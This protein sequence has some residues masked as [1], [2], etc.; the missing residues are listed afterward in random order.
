MSRTRRRVVFAALVAATVTILAAWLAELLAAGGFVLASA[1]LV[2]TFAVKVAWVA[3][4]FWNAVIGFVLLRRGRARLEGVVAAP[5]APVRDRI[6]VAMTVCNENVAHVIARLRSTKQSLDAGGH[7]GHFDFF[8]LSDSSDPAIAAA[9]AA[10]IAKWQAELGGAKNLIYRRREQNT[11]AQHGNLYDFCRRF[12]DGYDV[13]IV[14]DADSLMT[15]AAICQLVQIMQANPRIGMLQSVNSG[16]LPQ[17]LFARIFEFGHRH[18]MRCWMA[19]AVWWQGDRGQY[20]GHNA[21]IRVDAYAKNCSLAELP[22]PAPFGGVMFCHDQ[23]ESLLMH[24]AGFEVR[25][26]P[27]EHG[28]FEGMP[29]TLIDFVTRYCRWLQGN[30]TNLRMLRLGGLAAMD[31]YHLIGVA[32]RFMTWPAVVAFVALAAFLSLRWP[33]GAP[34]S[35]PS[36]LALYAT[37]FVIYFTPKLL[38]VLD[39][40]L[41]AP[42]TYGGVARLAAGTSLDVVLTVLFLPVTMLTATWFATG[43]PFGRALAWD[44]QKREG[45]RLSWSAAAQ[46]LWPHTA[47]GLGLLATLLVAAPA[48]VPWFLPFCAGLV[49]AIPFAAMTSS[50]RLNRLAARWKLFAL[51][52]DIATP[53][54]IASVLVL[55]AASGE[56]GGT[57]I[58]S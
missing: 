5:P 48:A 16:I 36:A 25:E 49:V 40:A 8:L 55:E 30:F 54:E 52:E 46:T 27:M 33:S 45:Y 29:P 42:K 22:G 37:Y 47:I 7:G 28:S 51:P 12:G 39:S 38:G 50:A 56:S 32:H 31:R 11:G 53:P 2:L 20:R 43:L 57:E 3:I 34:F 1:L 6:A 41:R 13:M 18:F 26:L 21:A 9:E 24:R 23:I 15:G 10:A 19:G 58:I 17:S 4:N 14:L 44:S 35:V